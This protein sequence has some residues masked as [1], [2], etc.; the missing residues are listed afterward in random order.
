LSDIDIVEEWKKYGIVNKGITYSSVGK[1]LEDVIRPMEKTGFEG[2]NFDQSWK[3]TKGS[4][5]EKLVFHFIQ[6]DVEERGLKIVPGKTIENSSGENELS[7]LKS[8]LQIPIGN[9]TVLPDIDLVIFCPK[10]LKV[11]AIISLKT[12]LRERASQTAY[13]KKKLAEN[14]P[15][16]DVKVFFVTIDSDNV[17]G[18]DSKPRKIVEYELDGTFFLNSNPVEESD[19]VKNFSKFSQSL[20]NI[21]EM[22]DDS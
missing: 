1:F 2:T 16:K 5:L 11:L 15:T 10:P 22:C 4:H 17:L 3:P 18:R 7:Q 6:N 13:W 12:S 9:G 14:P 8:L 20:E 19:T 21:K